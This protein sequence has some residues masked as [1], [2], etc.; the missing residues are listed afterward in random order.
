MPAIFSGYWWEEHRQPQLPV[1]HN[2]EDSL[3]F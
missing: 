2:G 3:Q 1:T